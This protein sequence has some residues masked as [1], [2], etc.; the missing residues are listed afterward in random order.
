LNLTE[1]RRD[2]DYLTER[3]EVVGEG[4]S[5]AGEGSRPI[6]GIVWAEW[7]VNGNDKRGG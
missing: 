5:I 1:R 7:I 2:T 6:E 4:K 3:K